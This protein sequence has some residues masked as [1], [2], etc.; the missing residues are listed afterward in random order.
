VPSWLN[1]HAPLCI[2]VWTSSAYPDEVV[3]DEQGVDAPDAT[4][5]EEEE[6]EGEGHVLHALGLHHRPLHAYQFTF[7]NVFLFFKT[8]Q[9]QT[10]T[11]RDSDLG[12][13]GFR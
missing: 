13:C 10:Q 6:G 12:V 8:T 7:E 1:L 4:V 9:F 2:C 3:L 5:E 11:A